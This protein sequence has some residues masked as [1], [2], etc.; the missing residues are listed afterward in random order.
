VA[1]VAGSRLCASGGSGGNFR[2]PSAPSSVVESGTSGL[3][4]S[5]S[6]AGTSNVVQTVVTSRVVVGPVSIGP[7]VRFN[8]P[9]GAPSAS[10]NG[11]V[12]LPFGFN[13]LFSNLEI[14]RKPELSLGANFAVKSP[15][16]LQNNEIMSKHVK[17][18]NRLA[19]DNS[20]V[21]ISVVSTTHFS[22]NV[23]IDKCQ[24]SFELSQSL[25]DDVCTKR[26][27]IGFMNRS[28]LIA[29]EKVSSSVIFDIVS[30]D[31]FTALR[32]HPSLTHRFTSLKAYDVVGELVFL[33]YLFIT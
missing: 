14:F 15:L 27:Y 7:V 2:V 26:L 21:E 16:P 33:N 25:L 4:S 12:S 3:S 10:C 31:L 18:V 32:N 11:R 20:L 13:Y 5:G 22:S 30:S 6:V 29:T 9:G 24:I 23:T 19:S 28:F 17:A 1:P 8:R